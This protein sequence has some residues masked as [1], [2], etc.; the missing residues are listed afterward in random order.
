MTPGLNLLFDIVHGALAFFL[1]AYGIY[2]G[3]RGIVALR[4]AQPGQ[5]HLSLLG[6]GYCLASI[7]TFLFILCL[8]ILFK[9]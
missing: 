1:L 5:L 8:V 2:E 3:E 7:G 9:Q 4:K 6:I